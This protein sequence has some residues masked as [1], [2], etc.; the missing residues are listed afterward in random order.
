MRPSVSNSATATTVTIGN[1]IGGLGA[2]SERQLSSLTV[3]AGEKLG[4]VIGINI[5]VAMG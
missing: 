5:Y 4:S 2:V 3:G 1:P